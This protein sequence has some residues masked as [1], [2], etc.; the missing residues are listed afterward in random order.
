[1]NLRRISHDTVCN[2]EGNA[3]L[4]ICKS[5]NLCI[6]NGRCGKDKNLGSFTFKHTS[7]I[8]YSI[9]TVDTFK[10]IDD[11]EVTELDSLFF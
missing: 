1:M 4:E 11:F 8:D 2:N 7:V 10:F 3:L 6:L 9:T 5:N